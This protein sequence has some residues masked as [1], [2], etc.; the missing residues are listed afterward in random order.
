MN[1]STCVR[2]PSFSLWTCVG[3]S[4]S[5]LLPS[6]TLDVPIL[7]LRGR[8]S[9]RFPCCVRV[10]A[11]AQRQKAFVKRLRRRRCWMVI[12]PLHS[13]TSR[14]GNDLVFHLLFFGT[15]RVV[16]HGQG[17]RKAATLP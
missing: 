13:F 15:I 9:T 4:S 8:S 14:P 17:N 3:P 10:L 2:L 5:P 16:E 11:L 1:T 7:M 12:E 6:V